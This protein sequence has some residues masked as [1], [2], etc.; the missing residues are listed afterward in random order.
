MTYC[1]LASW[2]PINFYDTLL[3]LHWP[4]KRRNWGFP[5]IIYCGLGY[6]NIGTDINISSSS[7]D[8]ESLIVMADDSWQ[9]QRF[10]VAPQGREEEG[11][12]SVR[13]HQS[14]CWLTWSS[15]NI[16]IIPGRWIEGRRDNGLDSSYD[17]SNFDP[18]ISGKWIGKLLGITEDKKSSST[19]DDG[20][21]FSTN[22]R[23]TETININKSEDMK[24][25]ASYCQ[26]NIF[27]VSLKS[28]FSQISSICQMN[29][30]TT[31]LPM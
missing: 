8:Q 1:G 26:W 13:N 20:N 7:R 21:S 3:L 22:L 12:E 15:G 4:R 18:F 10:F 9:C 28:I 2:L 6:Q 29:I 11:S 16:G 23:E 31:T 27:Q 5:G 17:K 14:Y 19:V 30:S 25:M 24:K